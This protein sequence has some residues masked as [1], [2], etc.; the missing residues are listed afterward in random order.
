MIQRSD[1]MF[2]DITKMCDLTQLS[3]KQ[4][5]RALRIVGVVPLKIG[6][7]FGKSAHRYLRKDIMKLMPQIRKA[8]ETRK[9]HVRHITRPG[10]M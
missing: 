8:A 6:G 4:L 10:G 7:K 1:S 9:P 5:R 2:M 3:T